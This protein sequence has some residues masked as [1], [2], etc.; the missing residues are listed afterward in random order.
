MRWNWS[1]DFVGG[2]FR[3]GEM[4]C[5]RS[6]RSVFTAMSSSVN[7]FKACSQVRL[8]KFWSG[9]MCGRCACSYR[10]RAKIWTWQTWSS[11][12]TIYT[13]LH[14]N[15]YRYAILITVIG[16]KCVVRI[17]KKSLVAILYHFR[18]VS[19]WVM[20]WSWNRD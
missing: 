8:L 3:S 4:Q 5:P 19:L 12:L 13:Q 15:V 1:G 11:P 10:H 7:L 17:L 6:W 2:D 16:W 18:V 20:S 14:E 9:L